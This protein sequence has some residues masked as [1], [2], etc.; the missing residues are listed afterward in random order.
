MSAGEVKRPYGLLLKLVT[1]NF[2]F[3]LIICDIFNKQMWSHSVSHK[4]FA[5]LIYCTKCCGG[6]GRGVFLARGSLRKGRG[7][8]GGGC[9]ASWSHSYRDGRDNGGW[10]L[11]LALLPY[12]RGARAPRPALET[13][14]SP[15]LCCRVFAPL[16]GDFSIPSLS[17][18][19]AHGPSRRPS[20]PAASLYQHA[21][22]PDSPSSLSQAALEP[23][24]CLSSTRSPF[25]ASHRHSRPIVAYQAALA[26]PNYSLKA[27]VGTL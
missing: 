17:W 27:A 3:F 10:P 18:A 20:K 14:P 7:W 23:F 6:L 24:F 9:K 11:I 21:S 5:R 13:M 19:T 15:D 1:R 2:F 22:C 12:I 8:G 26:F 25:Q 4:S 16:L